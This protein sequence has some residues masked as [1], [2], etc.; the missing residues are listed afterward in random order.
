MSSEVEMSQRCVS[1][2]SKV[3]PGERCTCRAKSGSEWCGRHETSKQRFSV[4]APAITDTV[5][6]VVPSPPKDQKPLSPMRSDAEQNAGQRIFRTW[7]RWLARRCGPLLWTR[8]ESNNPYD[9]YSSDPVA[10]IPLRDF[11][12]FV[13]GGKGYIMDAKSATSLLEHAAKQQ[14][15]AMNPFNR[16]PLPSVFLRRLV[17]HGV[18]G[19]WES[20]VA[21]T[22][23]TKFAMEVT[24]L[25]RTIEDLGYYTDP[26]W[27]L[28]LGAL[29]LQ[30]L[31]I[32]LADIWYHRAG[33][34]QADK[35]RIVPPPQRAFPMSVQGALIMQ[36]KALKPL[37][38][39]TC[40]AIATAAAAR[41]DRQ[42]GVMY[43]LGSLA[44]V[45]PGAAVAYPWLV[46]MFSPGVCRIVG[47][48]LMVMHTGVLA[49]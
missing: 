16:T 29:Q 45:S 6:H 3:N 5:A 46:D 35:A 17:R 36:L 14:E 19:K 37:L 1:I 24:D 22:P 33:L 15:P 47:N 9:F 8:E 18:T 10:E 40:A 48:Q 49:Y 42:T 26:H 7:R 11:V 30:R 25:F 41:A 44:L 34:S 4:V 12:S 28:E 21:M 43:V 31:Y 13:D 23:A 32:E 2:R 20:L 27:F 39:K 38:L